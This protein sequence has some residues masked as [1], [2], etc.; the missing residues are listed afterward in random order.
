MLDLLNVERGMGCFG[1]ETVP[2]F[3]DAA[4]WTSTSVRTRRNHC[5]LGESGIF[6]N[7][8]TSF[9]TISMNHIVR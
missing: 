2:E 9:S 7:P 8:I 6:N 3:E 4:R 5:C 1:P